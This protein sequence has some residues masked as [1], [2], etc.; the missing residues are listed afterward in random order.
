M[1]S[2]D[3]VHVLNVILMYQILGIQV[4]IITLL[5]CCGCILGQ[6]KVSRLIFKG[7]V[8]ISSGS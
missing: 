5:H 7:P 4:S 1:L 6:L 3:T 2:V 8:I